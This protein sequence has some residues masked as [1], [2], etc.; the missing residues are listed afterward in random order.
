MPAGVTI[1]H[2]SKEDILKNYINITTLKKIKDIN[3][4]LE[5]YRLWVRV[6][7]Y[8]ETVIIEILSDDLEYLTDFMNEILDE[9][10]SERDI[11]DRIETNSNKLIHCMENFEDRINSIRD[12]YLGTP[13]EKIEIR[14]LSK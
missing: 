13:K 10:L 12:R 7:S 5:K 2:I 9:N 6:N 1:K 4:D 14:G 3:I 11:L 8:D